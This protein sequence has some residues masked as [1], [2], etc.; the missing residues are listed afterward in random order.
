MAQ[1]SA[2]QHKR[3]LGADFW[4]SIILGL[5]LLIFNAV[6]YFQFPLA[7]YL[8]WNLLV[9]EDWALQWLSYLLLCFL[10]FF[11]IGLLRGHVIWNASAAARL[12][13]TAG[14][15]GILPVIAVSLVLGVVLGGLEGA[16]YI[17]DGLELAPFLGCSEILMSVGAA[18]LGRV[19]G[20]RF[21]RRRPT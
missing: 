17:A 11:L 4:L 14:L 8:G 13:V 20:S 2:R 1:E 12:S 3:R 6:Y 19:I 5:I 16:T 21:L 7:K 10:G 18:Q 15:I 9:N